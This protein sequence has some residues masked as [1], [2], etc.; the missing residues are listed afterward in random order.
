MLQRISLLV[1]GSRKMLQE[2]SRKGHKEFLCYF[3]FSHFY[4]FW[5]EAHF[6]ELV[7][8]QSRILHSVLVWP[9]GLGEGSCV[10]CPGGPG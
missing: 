3:F 6:A 1:F 2:C 4:I 8:G 10:L 5:V 7:A 9:L